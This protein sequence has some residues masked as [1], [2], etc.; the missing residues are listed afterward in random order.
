MCSDHVKCRPTLF[1]SFCTSLY[2][3]QL[4]CIYKSEIIRK[5]YVAYNNVFRLLCNE[6]RYCSAVVICLAMADAW[7]G[8]VPRQQGLFTSVSTSSQ[9]QCRIWGPISPALS[10]TI[11]IDYTIYSTIREV[12]Q[13][14][15]ILEYACV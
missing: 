12:V 2:T 13:L 10:P 11:I 6:P 1:R 14:C 5:L 8:C 3:C 4:W 15:H 7:L 9:V